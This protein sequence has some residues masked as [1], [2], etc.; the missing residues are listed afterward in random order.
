MDKIDDRF[1]ASKTIPY[2]I[3]EPSI[4][5]RIAW[6]VVTLQPGTLLSEYSEA[7]SPAFKGSVS[8]TTTT[9][10]VKARLQVSVDD[11]KKSIELTAFGGNQEVMTRYVNDLA[12][13]LDSS[14]RKYRGIADK[15]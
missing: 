6:Y 10:S 2:N 7:E 1:K 11:S 15:D 5:F 14:L 3:A 12:G 4:V 13:A 8:F 9:G